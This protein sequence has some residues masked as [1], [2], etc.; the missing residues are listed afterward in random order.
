MHSSCEMPGSRYRAKP[1]IAPPISYLDLSYCGPINLGGYLNLCHNLEL[2]AIRRNTQ[3]ILM[4]SF[5]S[6]GLVA[7]D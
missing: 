1:Q 3:D 5:T 2:I 6:T 7:I 4:F